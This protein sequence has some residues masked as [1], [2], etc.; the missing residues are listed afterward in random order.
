MG[1][2]SELLRHVLNGES[3]NCAEKD[4][5]SDAPDAGTSTES[6]PCLEEK[7]EG[8]AEQPHHE[9]LDDGQAYRVFISGE[10][11]NGKDMAGEEKS[12]QQREGIPGADAETALKCKKGHPGDTDD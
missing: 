5:K 4:C 7:R 3:K 12:A 10:I 6:R 9:D 1:R 8:K 11:L 2:G